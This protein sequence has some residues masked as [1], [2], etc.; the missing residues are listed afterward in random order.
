MSSRAILFV[1]LIALTGCQQKPLTPY[2]SADGKFEALFA[3]DP[4][5]TATAAAGVTLKL[6][7]TESFTRTLMVGWADLP[8][9]KWESEGRTNSRLF[10][11]RDGALET[12]GAKSNGTTKAILLMD[13]FPGIEFGGVA[14]GKHLRAKIYLVGHRLYQVLIVGSSPDLRTNQEAEDFFSA[15][16]IYDVEGLLPPG[17]AA[18]LPAKPSFPIESSGG[19]FQVSYPVKSKKFTRSIGG[20]ELTGYLSESNDSVCMVGYVDLPIPGGE[21]EAKVRERLDAARAAALADANA[22]LISEKDVTIGSGRPGREFTGSGDGKHLRGRV[23]LVGARLY[24]VTVHGAEAF[25]GSPDATEFL[26]SFE[27]Q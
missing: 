19:R 2:K 23:Y 12:V 21:P 7:T 16:K 15:F 11:A 17:S 5:V 14:D 27:L 4:N 22:T 10:D 8:I 24:Q 25:V 6:Y 26:N 1:S 3:G 18:E 13:R 20:H 9:P